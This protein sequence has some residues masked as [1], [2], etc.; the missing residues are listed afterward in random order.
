MDRLSKSIDPDTIRPTNVKDESL[1]GVINKGLFNWEE[2][3]L[4]DSSKD[5]G[6]L[7]LPSM[8][9]MKLAYK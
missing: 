4:I 5:E 7:D 2:E 3:D 6:W 8:N 1:A 9:Q